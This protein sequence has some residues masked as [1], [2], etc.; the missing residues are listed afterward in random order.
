M[1]KNIERNKA[2]RLGVICIFAYL[3]CYYA[4]NILS[5]ISPRMIETSAFTVE[6]IGTMSSLCMIAYAVGQLINGTLG[7]RIKSKYMV[8]GVLFLS[9]I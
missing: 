6:S 2:V 7:D 3:A 1:Q 4:R 5:A 8:C 9:G